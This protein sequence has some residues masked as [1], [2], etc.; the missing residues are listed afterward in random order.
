M[1]QN[2]TK[3]TFPKYFFLLVKPTINLSTKK[4]YEKINM[5]PNKKIFKEENDWGNDFENIAIEEYRE[6][7][8]VLKF[9]QNIE[10]CIFARMTGSGSCCFGVFAKAIEANKARK[11]FKKKYPKLWSFVGENNTNN[12]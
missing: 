6:I 2:I 12:N 7:K 11:N 3:Q 10:N 4:M 1:G 9:I 5:K 8:D